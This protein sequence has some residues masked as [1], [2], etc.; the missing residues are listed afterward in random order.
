MA[1]LIMVAVLQVQA[2]TVFSQKKLNMDVKNVHLKEVLRLIMEQTEYRL[3]YNDNTLPDNKMVSLH[4]KNASLEEVLKTALTGTGF[5]YEIRPSGLVLIE[6][7]VQAQN[8]ITVTGVVADA[9]GLPLPGVTVLQKNTN[10][11]ALT[12]DKGV[13]TLTVDG[14]A[15]LTFSLIGFT[16][17]DIPVNNRT[18][19]DVTL[20]TAT[21]NLD[22]VVVVGYGTQKKANL[23]GAVG[24]VNVAQAF[25]SRPV[26]NAQELLAG[27]VP[28]LNVS[29]GSGAVGSGASINI[30]GTATIGGSSGVLTLIDGIPGNINTLNPNDIASVSV[31]KD[32][33]SAAIYGSRAANGVILI[34]TKKGQ[35]GSKPAVDVSSSVGVQQPQFRLDFVGAADYMKLWD[36]AL[37]NDGKA[38]VYGQQG[39]DDLKAGK[40]PD[41]RWYKDIYKKNTVIN[42]NYVSVAGQKDDITYRLSGSYDYQDGTLP[43]NDYRRY[44]VRPDMTIKVTRNVSVSANIQYTETQI[45][46]PQGGTTGWQSQAARISPISPITS[47]TGQYGLGSSMAGNP[48]AGVNEGGANKNKVKELMGIF[49]I[50]YTPAKNWNIKGSYARYSYDSWSSSR[51]NTYNLYDDQGNI[52]AVKNQVNNLTNS[53]S[54][55]YRNTLQLITDYSLSMGLHHF[56]GLAGFS[57]ELYNNNNFFASRDGMPFDNV[58]V[59]DIGTLNKQNGGSAS[60]VAIQSV[61]GRLNYDYDG[62]YLLEANVRG[63]GSSRFAPGHRWGIFPSFSAGWN[64]HRENFIKDHFNWISALKLRASWGILGDAEKVGY[65]PTAQVLTFVPNIYGFNSAIAPGAYSETA[66]NPNLSWEEAKLGNIGL[67]AGFLDN[68]VGFTIDYFINNRTKILYQAPVSLE[69]GL[70][71]PYSNLLSMQNK[72]LEVL[73]YYKDKQG[74]FNWGVNA[75]ASYSKNKIT[76][77]AGTGPWIGSNNYTA[78]GAQYQVPYGLQAI[79]LFQSADEIAK[80]PNQGPN[81]FPGNIKYKDQNNDGKIDGNDRVVLNTKVPIRFALNLNA[82]WKNFDFSANIYGTVNT[83]RYISGYEGWAFYLSQNARPMHLDAWTPENPHASYP[84]LSIQYTSNDT[85][86]SSYW[87]R[88]ADYLKLQNMQLGYTLPKRALDRLKINY[89]RVYVSGQNLATFS[90]YAGFDPEGGY[91][92]L[93]KTWA[94]GVNL[95]F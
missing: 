18:T 27:T 66:V 78:E 56:K 46:E 95:K 84:R 12:N 80:S 45:T 81:I 22:Q 20:R 76:N 2:S 40:I 68:K 51:L 64:I 41:N 29:K 91:Y 53:A 73:L 43:N 33:A 90:G 65:Y 19:L 9:S 7:G 54:S 3:F 70:N 1:V 16:P 67:D 87:L 11:G 44:T 77:L 50:T 61:F 47:A 15:I 58:N 85:K 42:N 86:Y 26:T 48:I 62:K 63:D 94:F 37:V 10:K 21:S 4:A 60:E 30:R 36:A 31:L 6:P 89:L 82:G 79:G 17:Q 13:Y 88:K 38:P 39:Q 74:D 34:T 28:G 52:A 75:N 14:D 72:G 71:A 69:F 35:A 24:T 83:Y 23:T 8:M 57:Q 49:D 25:K 92:P 32:A 59:L 5:R 55:S 93:S